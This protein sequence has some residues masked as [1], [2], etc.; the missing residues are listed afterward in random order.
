LNFPNFDSSE[1]KWVKDN[2][3]SDLVKLIIEIC[4]NIL[5]GNLPIDKKSNNKLKNYKRKM[6]TIIDSQIPIDQHK[7][8]I[9]Q[10]GFLGALLSTVGS[11]VISHLLSNL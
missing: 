10:G 1:K 6:Q 2:A 11:S 5:N 4:A 8:T 9:Q 3:S 7:H